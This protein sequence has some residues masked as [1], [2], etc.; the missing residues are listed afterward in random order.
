[1][2]LIRNVI[3]NLIRNVMGKFVTKN[4]LCYILFEPQ[5]VMERL[6]SKLNSYAAIKILRQKRED[7]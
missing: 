5:L 7:K 4:S 1:M 3:R 2:N 6:Y